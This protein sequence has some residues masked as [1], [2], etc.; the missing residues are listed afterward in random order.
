MNICKERERVSVTIQR[1][2]YSK[3]TDPSSDWLKLRDL[4]LEACV[5]FGTV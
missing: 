4:L 2:K 1:Q 5:P 3:V